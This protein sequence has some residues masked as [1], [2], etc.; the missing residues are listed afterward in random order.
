MCVPE[1]Q[2][3]ILRVHR[4]E[5]DRLLASMNNTE[6]SP[7]E[8][9]RER[10]VHCT[11]MHCTAKGCAGGG[12]GRGRPSRPP[13]PPSPPFFFVPLAAHANMGEGKMHE[14]KKAE[15]HKFDA[16]KSGARGARKRCLHITDVM[17]S[18][19]APPPFL[20]PS[21]PP[22]HARMYALRVCVRLPSN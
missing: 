10:E 2:Q 5:R 16:G 4:R 8:K 18:E 14:R 21:L 11:R 17:S 6:V 19:K 22:L 12:R 1:K 13:T 20:P 7:C 3:K 9:L 15:L